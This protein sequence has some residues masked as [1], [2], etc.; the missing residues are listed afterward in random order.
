MLYCIFANES[1]SLA[2]HSHPAVY[3]A[4]WVLL[5]APVLPPEDVGAAAAGLSCPSRA[6]AMAGTTP[7][8][9]L[10]E[11]AP[12]PPHCEHPEHALVVQAHLSLHGDECPSHQ[13]SHLL[14][15]LKS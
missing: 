2:L 10:P 4:A 14:S 1:H 12:P 15:A 3:M 11:L 13:L 5:I 8:P 7:L 9:G 6:A